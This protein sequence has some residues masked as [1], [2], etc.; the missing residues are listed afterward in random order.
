MKKLATLFADS[1]N[2]LRSPRTLAVCGM[3]M[4]L[5]IVLRFLAIPITPDIRVS[6]SYLGIVIIA[7]LYGP[8]P[9]TIAYIGSD[10]L[11]YLIA[12]NKL[13]DYN[14]LLLL[15]VI[16]QALIYGIALYRTD[17]LRQGVSLVASRVVIVLL[18]NIVLNTCIMY[19]CY[20]NTAFPFLEG[21]EWN[22]FWLYLAPRAGKALVQLPLDIILMLTAVPAAMKAYRMV[23]RTA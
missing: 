20:V 8:V 10:I 4:A 11:G 9:A 5:S 17:K 23:V 3:M 7:V 1:A 6:F 21:S 22:A 14:L 19:G 13:R 12:D 2:E 18:C 16:L 15:V